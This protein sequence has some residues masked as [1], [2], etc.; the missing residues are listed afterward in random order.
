[1]MIF[2]MNYGLNSA[3][4]FGFSLTLRVIFIESNLNFSVYYNFAV[5]LTCP[6]GCVL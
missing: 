3:F 4:V 5:E 6:K 1:M 2:F